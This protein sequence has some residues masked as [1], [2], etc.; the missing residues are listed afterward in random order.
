MRSATAEVTT[1]SSPPISTTSSTIQPSAEEEPRLPAFGIAAAR[2][3]GVTLEPISPHALR[4][5]PDTLPIDLGQDPVWAMA[6]DGR[7]LAVGVRAEGVEEIPEG[8]GPH[9]KIEEGRPPAE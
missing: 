3:R 8:Y 7:T 6:P 9:G 2:V 5:L 4:R 1:T